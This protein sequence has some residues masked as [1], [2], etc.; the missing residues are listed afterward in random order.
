MYE[1]RCGPP[2]TPAPTAGP[3]VE[4]TSIID[5]LARDNS[6][7]YAAVQAADL[8]ET[9]REARS[10][11]LWAPNDVAF[12]NYTDGRS[13]VRNLVPILTAPANKETL[14]KILLA[15]AV[16]GFFP[17]RDLVDFQSLTSLAGNRLIVDLKNIE[18][19]EDA[20][21]GIVH[22]VTNLYGE[23]YF[24]ELVPPDGN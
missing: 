13:P 8:V 19:S 6:I 15:H 22:R 14:G 9:L 24:S 11:T 4:C 2:P 20:C 16:D 10:L 17:E 1:E 3:T 18:S 12:T 23:G 5:I 21:N 7:I